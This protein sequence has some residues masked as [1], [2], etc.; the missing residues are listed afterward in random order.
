MYDFSFFNPTR[1][2]FGKNAISQ[3]ADWI[4]RSAKVLMTYG[5]GS[6]KKNGVYDRVVKAL[7]T[8]EL[9]EFSGIEP[10]PTY[11]TLMEAVEH[12]KRVDADFLLAV[13]GGSVVDGTKFIAAASRFEEGDPWSLLEGARVEAAVPMACVLTLPATGSESNSGAVISHKGKKQKR[14]FGSPHC[15]PQF[16]AL[17]PTTTFSLDK[18]QTVNGVVDAYVHVLEQY[19]TFPV[20]SPL[21]DRMAEGIL[22]T[23]IEEAP[24]VLENPEDYEARANIMWCCTQALNGL[25]GCGVPHDW[26]THMIGHELTALF[27][28]DHAQTLAVVLPGVLRR[29]LKVKTEKLAQ[30]SRRVWNL[31]DPFAAIEATEMFFRKIGMRTR[32][33]EYGIE[34]GFEEVPERLKAKGFVLGEHRDI[35][36]EHSLEILKTRV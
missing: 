13:G 30:Y 28:L 1:I 35:Q 27:G 14:F 3:I 16:A 17:D 9:H 10:N 33:S 11:E 2:L 7:G 4:P 8:R 19:L 29:Q 12:V 22:L 21:Q 18:R 36:P 6:I 32:L 5:G 26:A 24:K 25:I 31:E 23:L 15:Y 20:N 34:A